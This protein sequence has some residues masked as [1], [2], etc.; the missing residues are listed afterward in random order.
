VTAVFDCHDGTYC[1]WRDAGIRGA[2]AG[3]VPLSVWTSYRERRLID[4]DH[5]RLA[6]LHLV[7]R[8]IA[9][10]SS[11]QRIAAAG[12]PLEEHA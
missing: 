7:A 4:P 9:A 8:D 1:Y 12:M 10:S 2:L 5:A 6:S 3:A 11:H